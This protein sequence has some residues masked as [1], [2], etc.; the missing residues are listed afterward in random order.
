MAASIEARLEIRDRVSHSCFGLT[1]GGHAVPQ[2]AILDFTLLWIFL[3][4]IHMSW[5][6]VLDMDISIF[7]ARHLR[8]LSSRQIR[9][10]VLSTLV[11]SD[12]EHIFT[13]RPTF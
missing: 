8:S 4:S 10:I 1:P 12:M 13:T 3:E 2:I 9:N 11:N 7:S 6:L 5:I